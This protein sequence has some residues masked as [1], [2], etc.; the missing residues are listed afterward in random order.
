MSDGSTI[1]PNCDTTDIGTV[2]LGGNRTMAA[3][4][5]TPYNGQQLVLRIDQG[6]GN[7][8]LTWNSAYRFSG[9]T[10]PTLSTGAGATD[11]LGF[12]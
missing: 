8:T 9:G 4:S 6:S 7:R 10:A 5:G 2:T 12:Q 3:P 1:T 11:Y